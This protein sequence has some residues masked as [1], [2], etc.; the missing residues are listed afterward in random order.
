[1][2]GSILSATD[3]VAVVAVLKELGASAKLA[4][5]IEGESLVN[6]GTAFVVFTVCFQMYLNDLGVVGPEA[7][8]HT[9]FTII[10]SFIRLSIGGL[11]IGWLFGIAAG[12]P[13]RAAFD[14]AG[15]GKLVD[16]KTGMPAACMGIGANDNG[17]AA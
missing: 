17:P 12:C 13:G 1:M 2:L 15:C 6:D 3:P 11:L 16:G 9:A 8:D 5:I 14:A 7:V 10:W 4:T